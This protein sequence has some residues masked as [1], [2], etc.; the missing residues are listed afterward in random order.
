MLLSEMVSTTLIA[1]YSVVPFLKLPAGCFVARLSQ[2][3][4]GSGPSQLISVRP[5]QVDLLQSNDSAVK[6][7]QNI[8]NKRVTSKALRNQELW[9]F[10]HPAQREFLLL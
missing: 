2:S 8:P 3:V 6:S 5:L 7:G 1:S 9:F 10:D 4:F